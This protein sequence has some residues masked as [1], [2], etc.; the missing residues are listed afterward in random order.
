MSWNEGFQRKKFKQE[1]EETK[2]EYLALGMDEKDFEEFSETLYQE[3]TSDRHY[4]EHTASLFA[5]DDSLC[6]IEELMYVMRVP[7]GAENHFGRIGLLAWV[8]EIENEAVLEAVLS[9]N[10]DSLIVVSL[11]I[12]RKY[13]FEDIAA[14]LGICER[15]ARRK[16]H[17]A[18]KTLRRLLQSEGG[19]P[20]D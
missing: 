20:I 17:D 13:T 6:S 11:K 18:L 8:T 3:Y 10:E 2:Q 7:N 4:G 14:E 9:L 16:Y 1:L 5:E 12:F 15:T 19:N